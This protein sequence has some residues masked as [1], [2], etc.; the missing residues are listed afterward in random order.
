MSAKAA[1]GTFSISS[2]AS[3][4]GVE[5]PSSACNLTSRLVIGSC[6]GWGVFFHF[7][8]FFG[9]PGH[10]CRFLHVEP[11]LIFSCWGLSG[12]DNRVSGSCSRTHPESEHVAVRHIE[13]GASTR[14]SLAPT[15]DLLV[16]AISNDLQQGKKR[17]ER[18][19]ENEK[20]A[21]TEAC[22][23][24]RARSR[25]NLLCRTS[26]CCQPRQLH[27]QRARAALQM[28]VVRSRFPRYARSACLG[29]YIVRRAVAET[30][31]LLAR[32]L[33]PRQ[34]RHLP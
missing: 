22:H 27:F 14:I 9:F 26:L 8:F 33:G 2:A 30:A 6:W 4:S 1:A 12:S 16:F 15:P 7:F 19:D 24:E 28:G 34:P 20:K 11:F 18:R 10:R 3:C 23:D 25:T 5:T 13:T 29:L 32:T 31:S 21:P 17:Q